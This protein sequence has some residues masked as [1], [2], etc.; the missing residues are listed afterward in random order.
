MAKATRTGPS[1]VPVG[2]AGGAAGTDASVVMIK[3]SSF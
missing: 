2:S 1:L 3:I